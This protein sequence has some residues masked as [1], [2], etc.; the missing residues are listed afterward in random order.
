MV[1]AHAAV[2]ALAS[3]EHG[4]LATVSASL[5]GQYYV[6]GA[7]PVLGTL[8]G[9]YGL[10][11]VVLFLAGACGALLVLLSANSLRQGHRRFVMVG[12][13]LSLVLPFVMLT[14]DVIMFNWC[15]LWYLP[16]LT[17]IPASVVL[18]EALP[19]LPP[20]PRREEW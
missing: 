6:G 13:L 9:S 8:A 19:H 5:A 11:R 16:T 10:V 14:V 20:A 1:V 17:A 2:I 18:L 7:D 15:T 4:V 3:L 12:G